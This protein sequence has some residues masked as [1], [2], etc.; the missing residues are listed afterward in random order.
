MLQ[1][2]DPAVIKPFKDACNEACGAWILKYRCLK[3]SF[4][5]IAGIVDKAFTKICRM[6]IAK[7]AFECT[8]IYPLN[9]RVFS[10]LGLHLFR[11]G[12]Y[13]KLSV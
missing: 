13:F 1:P 9:S 2:F 6:E 4:N 12:R 11:R 5:F 3:T 8:G 10:N 7:K